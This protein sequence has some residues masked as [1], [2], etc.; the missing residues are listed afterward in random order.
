MN[1]QREILAKSS[2]K[3]HF[4]EIFP[5]LAICNEFCVRKKKISQYLAQ[6]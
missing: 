1:F 3:L 6:K 5:H 4:D 2:V